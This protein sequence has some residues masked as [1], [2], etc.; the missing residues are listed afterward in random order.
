MSCGESS[1]G[2]LRKLADWRLSAR[3]TAISC[4]GDASERATPAKPI[5]F[6]TGSDL[7]AA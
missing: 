2:Y 5:K 6:A 3:W 7:A 1:T 4:L